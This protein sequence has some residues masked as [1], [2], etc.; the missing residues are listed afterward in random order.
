MGYKALNINSDLTSSGNVTTAETTFDQFTLDSNQLNSSGDAIHIVAWGTVANNANV[1]TL[2]FYFGTATQAFVLPASTATN[3]KLDVWIV[4]AS[5]TS[6]VGIAHM[7]SGVIATA[8]SDVF[9]ITATQNTRNTL[10]VKTTGTAT[11]TD[12]ILQKGMLVL[13]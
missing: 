13:V 2:T 9:N 4:A 5:P 1:K 7:Q 8:T 10:V 11:S 12:D 6:Q 3:W